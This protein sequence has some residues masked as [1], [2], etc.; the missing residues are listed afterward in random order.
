[1][2]FACPIFVAF[3]LSKQL[4]SLYSSP[5]WCFHITKYLLTR[6]CICAMSWFLK[7]ESCH[8]FSFVASCDLYLIFLKVFPKSI[9]LL[10][11]YRYLGMTTRRF[12]ATI[13]LQFCNCID[14]KRT[15]FN[16]FSNLIATLHTCLP[17]HH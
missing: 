12:L 8:F 13:L 11:S 5:F 3:Q 1:M 14:I 15:A 6:K 7:I 16:T 9:I 4:S 17:P 10:R 2:C